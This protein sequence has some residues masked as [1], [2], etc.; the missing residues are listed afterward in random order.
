MLKILKI[1]QLI[2]QADCGT[3]NR[4]GSKQGYA[5]ACVIHN[6]SGSGYC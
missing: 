3:Q 4:L 2:F 5:I 6:N 1:K